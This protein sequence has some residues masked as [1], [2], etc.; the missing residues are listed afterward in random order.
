MSLVDPL[1]S[2][3][4]KRD[5]GRLSQ[6]LGSIRIGVNQRH[7][8]GMGHHRQNSTVGSSDTSN[9]VSRAVGVEGVPLSGVAVVVDVPNSS[10]MLGS[11]L[12]LLVLGG[13]RGSALTMGNGNGESRTSHT[14]K[15]NAGLLGLID[16][17]D[18]GGSAFVLLGGISLKGGPVVS[19]GNYLL[20]S[21]QELATVADTK[22]KGVGSLK[23]VGE[24]GLEL[25]REKY[26][27]R[28]SSSGT[29]NITVGETSTGNETNEVGE[30]LTFR[31]EV[32]HMDIDGSEAGSLETVG[33]LHVR[34]DT[35]LSEDGNLR[36]LRDQRLRD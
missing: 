13:K 27:L 7:S 24:L 20:E 10:Q 15:E 26:R 12:G 6:I 31:R 9:G 30:L 2:V 36:L 3:L 4:E 22:S 17:L 28:P 21:R 29:E 18:H 23:E 33:H 25:G 34:I 14:A 35:L 1:S 16:N 5:P 8:L 19:S 11:K 32:G